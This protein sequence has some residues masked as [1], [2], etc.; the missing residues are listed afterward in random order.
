MSMPFIAGSLVGTAVGG[1]VTVGMA[2]LAFGQG[3]TGAWWL[4]VGSI[5]LLILGVFFARKVRGAALYTLPELVESQY[6]RRVG[7]AAS[8]LI[9]VA[10]IGVVAGQIAAA[11]KVLSILG[12]GSV[13]FWM[14]IFSLVLIAYSVLGGQLAAIGTDLF[15]AIMIYLGI[16]IGLGLVLTQ[17]G[18][19]DGLRL[20]LPQD[21]F[22]FPVSSQ[23]N[24]KA[25]L[26]LFI[27]VGATYV[28]GPD[29]YTRLFCARDEK[30]AQRATFLSAIFFVPLAFAVVLIG[31]SAKVL[32]PEITP[33]QAF[34][35]V[36]S[37][38]PSPVLGGLILTALVVAP[39]SS[40]LLNQAVIL[41][42]DIVKRFYPS[43]SEKRT[44]L[45]TR[46]NIIILGFLALGLAMTLKGVISS[47]LFAY[48]IFTCGLVVPVIAG[49]YKEKLKV[50]AQGALAAL[51][52]GGVIGLMGKIPGLAIPLKED[53]GLIGFAVS[54]VLLFGVSYLGLRRR[55]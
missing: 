34:P 30:T 53:L 25:L 7:L 35:K 9:V 50:T 31:M 36:I 13:N 47:L 33:E 49:F 16:F 4:L 55:V 26:S 6:D 28:V 44:I 52:G 54:A 12:I 45:L 5:G 41:T 19:L 11:G 40:C 18:G 20:S 37:A 14:V 39:L 43:L 1:S 15:Q 27:L 17:V 29:M 23:F 3:L 38:I 10:W 32:Y 51:I 22:S 42:Q 2:G 48:T 8:I 46:L 24:W 21:F